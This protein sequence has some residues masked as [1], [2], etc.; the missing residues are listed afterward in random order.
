LASCKVLNL[1]LN[2]A[3]K[4]CSSA[5]NL[6]EDTEITLI[7]KGNIPNTTCEI[8]FKTEDVAGKC[9]ICF[10]FERYAYF[11]T[12]YVTLGV[13]AGEMSMFIEDTDGF[14]SVYTCTDE[15]SLALSL[16]HG[17][18]YVYD[19]MEP[20][21]TFILDVYNKCGYRGTAKSVPFKEVV[22]HAKGYHHGK[23]KIHENEMSEFVTGLIVGLCLASVFLVV[24]LAG[25][26][27]V[28]NRQQGGNA[29]SAGGR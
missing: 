11:N 22:S 12:T 2:A 17:P 3:T 19:P 24:L 4:L 20:G 18:G 14:P 7:S 8:S 6:Q 16:I 25:W 10:Q 1:E 9:G 23:E 21:Y 5:Q 27:Y 13:K 26:C 28:K 29:K 15:S